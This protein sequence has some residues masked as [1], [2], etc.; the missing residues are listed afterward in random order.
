MYFQTAS[1]DLNAKAAAV[2]ASA[3]DVTR[4]FYVDAGIPR[5]RDKSITIEYPDTIPN[6]HA[7]GVA[8]GFHIRLED[9]PP[10]PTGATAMHEMGHV[11]HHISWRANYRAP[12]AT[13]TPGGFYRRDTD[14]TAWRTSSREWPAAAFTEAVGSFVRR[15]SL[16]SR[17]GGC[18]HVAFDANA[19]PGGTSTPFSDAT[20]EDLDPDGQVVCNADP[21]EYPDDSA[22]RITYPNDGHSYQRNVLRLL[23]DFVDTATDDD[24]TLAGSGDHFSVPLAEMWSIFEGMWLDRTD[25]CLDVCDFLDYYLYTVMDPTVVGQSTHDQSVADITDLALQNGI[26]CGPRP[27]V[28]PSDCLG[29]AG[30]APGLYD[31]ETCTVDGG[32]EPWCVAVGPAGDLA[33]DCLTFDGTS[34]N[35]IVAIEGYGDPGDIVV[36]GDVYDN[37]LLPERFCCRFDAADTAGITRIYLET[38]PDVATDDDVRLTAHGVDI[39]TRESRIVTF[40]GD[41]VVHGGPGPDGVVTG[42]GDDELY[43]YEGDDYLHAGDDIDVCIGGGGSDRFPLDGPLSQ[44]VCETGPGHVTL[45]R[46]G[47]VIA[48][49]LARGDCPGGGI[50]TLSGTGHPDSLDLECDPGDTVQ[51]TCEFSNPDDSVNI[52]VDGIS[53]R[54]CES[55]PCTHSITVGNDADVTCSF[56]D[57]D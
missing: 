18:D 2:F 37:P 26:T 1:Y 32:T 9:F 11:M 49:S 28:V 27:A 6:P 33:I 30:S 35:D 4:A 5:R 10:W 38:N 34:T 24:P 43:T 12:A 31:F 3:V 7:A 17:P 14:E 13:C 54:Y 36:F 57:Y 51:I 52:L 50:D 47:D 55:S 39:G 21:L 15:A 8:V 44:P 41:D 22:T 56:D 20:N 23:C 42:E 19:A 48:G 16:G 53:E 29:A 25:D 46:G 45:R 40:G